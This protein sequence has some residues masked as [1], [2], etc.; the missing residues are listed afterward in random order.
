MLLLSVCFLFGYLTY[1]VGKAGISTQ[2]RKMTI[3]KTTESLHLGRSDTN[4]K[5]P[6]NGCRN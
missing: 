2:D 5:V 4:A 6:R 3:D 1:A